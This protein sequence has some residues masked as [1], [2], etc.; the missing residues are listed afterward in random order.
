MNR[1]GGAS[2]AIL[3]KASITGSAWVNSTASCW[4]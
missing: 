1:D 3:G 4:P 2:G